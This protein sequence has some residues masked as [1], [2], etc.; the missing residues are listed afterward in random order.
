VTVHLFDYEA[1]AFVIERLAACGHLL[2]A[3]QQETG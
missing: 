1:A 3:G 2:Q